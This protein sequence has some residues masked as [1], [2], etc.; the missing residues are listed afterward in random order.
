MSSP[1]RPMKASDV[2][3]SQNFWLPRKPCSFSEAFPEIEDIQIELSEEGKEINDYDRTFF[4]NMRNPPGEYAD[5]HNPHCYNGGI[6]IGQIL[7]HMVAT[8]KSDYSA[9]E[10]CQGYEGS[11]KGRRKYGSCDN[12]FS[13]KVRLKLRKLPEQDHTP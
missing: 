7:R 9:S 10:R 5:C 12:W 8:G 4:F 11:P 13:L 3:S 2:C 1:K 6:R